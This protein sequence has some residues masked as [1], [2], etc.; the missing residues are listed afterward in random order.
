MAST[1]DHARAVSAAFFTTTNRKEPTMTDRLP[2]PDHLYRL[3]TANGFTLA[4][5][6]RGSARLV[7]PGGDE[8]WDTISLPNAGQ[9]PDEFAENMNAVVSDLRRRAAWGKAAEAVLA[10]TGIEPDP[11]PACPPCMGDHIPGVRH[12]EADLIPVRLSEGAAWFPGRDGEP[13]ELGDVDSEG[14][15]SPAEE[16]FGADMLRR[17]NE[18]E[19]R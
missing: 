16:M 13:V 19:P 8:R 2:D 14:R 15:P 10:A 9:Y 7:W 12:A 18:G 4:G 17:L 11:Q 3:L 5:R 6:S 1:A